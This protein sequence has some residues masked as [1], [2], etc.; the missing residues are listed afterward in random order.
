MAARDLE[1]AESLLA[2]FA[3]A[4]LIKTYAL[5]RVVKPEGGPAKTVRA[6]Q[7]PPKDWGRI[8]AE[9]K[10]DVALNGGTVRL[11]GSQ[12]K[13][14]TLSRPDHRRRFF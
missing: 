1:D 13:G 11:G 9:D 8:V 7:I 3:A 10:V 5:V 4:G 14:G 6:S 2:D 12:L